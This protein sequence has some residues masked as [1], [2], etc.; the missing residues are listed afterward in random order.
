MA[1]ADYVPG[2][3]LLTEEGL[4]SILTREHFNSA[5]G[6]EAY[7]GMTQRLRVNLS[8]CLSRCSTVFVQFH[9]KLI[10]CSAKW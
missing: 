3:F 7:G 4:E 9:F 1:A 10:A 6:K 5:V 8:H 2:S